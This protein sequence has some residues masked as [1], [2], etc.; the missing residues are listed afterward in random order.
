M[1][2]VQKVATNNWTLET[3]TIRDFINKS[4]SINCNPVGQR[5]AVSSNPIGDSKPSKEQGIINSIMKGGDIGEI[6]IVK[7]PQDDPSEFQY[8]S[9]DGGHRKRA[10]K[11]FLSNGF[12]LHKTSILKE[13]YA[14]GLDE[15]QLESFFNFKIRVVIYD[16]LTNR[17]KGE[18]FRDTNNTTPVK[19]QETL[20]SYGDAPIANLIR[21]TAR[22][23]EGIESFP[24]ELFTTY[25][26]TSGNIVYPNIAT[27][28]TR[29]RL[30]ELVARITYMCYR[31]EKPVIA[32]FE[33]IQS[34][35]D[36]D[37][38][39]KD[40]KKI[41][42]KLNNCLDFLYKCSMEKKAK[43][44]KGLT[45]AQT[46][47]LYRLYF[48]FKKTYGNFK[49]ESYE[50]FWVEFNE[51]FNVFNSSNPKRD[52]I[53]ENGRLI[54]EAFNQHL[55]EHK[56][57]FKFDNTIQWIL[58]EMNLEEATV[59]D[60]DNKRVFPREWVEMKLADQKYKCWVSGEELD[61]DDAQG[62]HIASYSSGGKTEYDNLVVISAEHNRR[63]QDQNAHDYKE[64]W[65]KSNQ[66]KSA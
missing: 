44:K 40:V 53:V 57:Q 16:N 12:P 2:K 29:L 36:S 51:A 52:D 20:N 15:E 11:E 41:E 17:E 8:E 60:R 59:A 43:L 5:P 4:I 18:A 3:W 7:L 22:K 33:G 55:G 49:I 9:I 1:K 58:E 38:S 62:G 39:V 54:Y 65:L 23:V 46:V 27:N 24:H 35:Y 19:N 34:M 64:A 45:Y 25:K 66:K 61:M 48:Y 37:P 6:K 63:M 28:N 50:K 32:P 13:V 26:T 30:D 42:K 21:Q 10:I 56:T 31:D 14:K 47:M